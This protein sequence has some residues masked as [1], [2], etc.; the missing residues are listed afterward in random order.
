[1][2]VKDI[3]QLLTAIRVSDV[4]SYLGAA[5]WTRRQFPRADVIVFTGPKANDGEAIEVVVP[6]LESASDFTD[7]IG[8]ILSTVSAIEDREPLSIAREILRPSLDHLTVRVAGKQADD[9]GL[10]LDVAAMLIK[11]TEKLL[12]ATAAAEERPVPYYG[13]ATKLA[14]QYSKACRFGQTAFG[15]FKINIECPT[16]S[17]GQQALGTPFPRRVTK[18]LLRGLG[19][20]HTAVLSGT[21]DV[22]AS[23]YADG[24]NANVCEA[25]LELREAAPELTLGFS[26]T[27]S[28]ALQLDESFLDE[29]VLEDRS[30]E[31]LDV[32]ARR[33]R[34][35]TPS[36][37]RDIDGYIV[38]LAADEVAETEDEEEVPDG[39]R[40]ATLRFVQ[41]GRRQHAV[42]QLDLDAYKAACDA[43]RD[44]TLVRVRGNLERVGRRWRLLGVKSFALLPSQGVEADR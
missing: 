5:G 33:M 3:S 23:G 36:G 20:L 8:E 15:S 18:R 2:T 10:P 26:A 44:R 21:P 12:T 40:V 39:E 9:G 41:D 1:M 29:V 14:V 11:G 42:M 27:F 31:F 37:E 7:R 32:A 17:V 43:H 19:Q 22:L 24:L 13:R 30:F 4:T 16:R 38:R 6:A 35:A 34:G 28:R 25:L